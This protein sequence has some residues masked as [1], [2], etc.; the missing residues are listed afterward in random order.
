VSFRLHA[1][2]PCL[3]FD[4][5]AI[6]ISYDERSLSLVRTLGF[7]H[8]D[9]DFVRARDVVG[10]VRDRCARLDDFSELRRCAQPIWG[11]LEGVM[12]NAVSSFASLVTAYAAERPAESF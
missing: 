11:G 6:N 4:A 3:S 10:D 5:P 8:W 1:F 7:G 2:V 12:R 9:I